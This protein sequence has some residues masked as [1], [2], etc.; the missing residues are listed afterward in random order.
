MQ[1]DK[2]EKELKKME[3]TC[4]WIQS[5]AGE[6]TGACVFGFRAEGASVIGERGPSD[7][8]DVARKMKPGKRQ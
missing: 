3:D 6:G 1:A 2:Y 4:A 8:P 5:R 7:R